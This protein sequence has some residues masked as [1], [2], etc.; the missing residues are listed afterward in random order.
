[1]ISRTLLAGLVLFGLSPADPDDATTRKV[2]A[3]LTTLAESPSKKER[4]DAAESLLRLG[5]P[6]V[7]A[8]MA[9]LN[10][11]KAT[12]RYHAVAILGGLRSDAAAAVPRLMRAVGSEKED[13]G[14]R[15]RALY[16]LG[17]IGANEKECVPFLLTT[18][19]GGNRDLM[20]L[21]GEAIGKFGPKAKAAVPGLV[22][23]VEGRTGKLDVVVSLLGKI[24]PDAKAAVPALKE[25]AKDAKYKEIQPDVE[26]A[27]GQIQPARR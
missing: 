24:G 13:A 8:L 10:D 2:N 16:S 9:A 26:A 12:I 19:Q 23:M 22:K 17:E 4:N 1:M 27:L 3:L 21:A 14:V 5:K 20:E 6:A 7:P 15:Q 25:L 11:R 18:F